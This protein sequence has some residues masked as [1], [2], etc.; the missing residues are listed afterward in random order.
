M[1]KW[2]E[3]NLIQEIPEEFTVCEYECRKNI[4]PYHDWS[5]CELRQQAMQSSQHVTRDDDHLAGQQSQ[6]KWQPIWLYEVL[7][8]VYILSGFACSYYFDS[9]FGYT[10]GA[11]LFVAALLVWVMRFRYRARKALSRE[12]SRYS[13][14]SDR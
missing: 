10:T 3:K 12:S 11:L 14:H 5:E 8:F 7:P 1:R 9:P 6:V 4:C 2:L 13:H